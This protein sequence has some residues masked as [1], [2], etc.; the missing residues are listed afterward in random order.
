MAPIE[1]MVYPDECDAYGHLNQAS[2]LSLFERARWEMLARGPGLDVFTREGA[3]PALRRTL[4]DYRASALPGDILVFAQALTHRGRTSFTMRQSATRKAD[5]ALVASAEFVFVCIDREGRPVEVPQA[6]DRNVSD[7]G[8]RAPADRISVNGV[9]LAVELE[10]D[11]P[12]VL[13]L[14]GFP[15]DRTMWRAPAESLAGWRRIAPDLRGMGKS[16]A[17]D[18]G[19]SMSTYAGDLLALL[20]RLEV[21]RVV[22]VGLS[23][24]GYIAF[25]MLR[26]A[27]HRI[28]G[29]VLM[30]TRAEADSEEGRRGR[31]AM[32]ASVRERGTVA[33]ADAMLPKLLAPGTPARDPGLVANL[34]RIVSDTPVS[35]VV[36]ALTAMRDR[37]DSTPLLATLAGL[38]TLVVGGEDDAII[39]PAATRDLA[40]AI[41][42]AELSIVPGAGHVPP[43]E[44]PGIT[45]GVIREFLQSLG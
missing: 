34:R 2:F 43:L 40:H 22:L 4:I 12:A 24:G 28:R 10:G 25:E 23:M 30:D 16:D 9:G 35:G 11:G 32:I 44:Q 31:E 21:E 18:L 6:I 33:V 5:G 7:S 26:Q 14:H 20:D 38:P 17:P 8:F 15:L 41:P 19:Y 42:G 3:W 1:L 39:P 36:G 29:L 37:P 13:F 27:R 45:S